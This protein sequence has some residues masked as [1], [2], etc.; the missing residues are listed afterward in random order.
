MRVVIE[1]INYRL[2]YVSVI[3]KDSKKTY[4]S[5]GE[6]GENDINF[7]KKYGEQIFLDILV[8]S[9]YFEEV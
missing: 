3:D 7:I 4:F 9:G 1:E 8:S 2:G 5:Q 6:E